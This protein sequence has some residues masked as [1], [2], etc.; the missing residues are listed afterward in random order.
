MNRA[1]TI[2]IA[3][4]AVAAGNLMAAVV[5]DFDKY[6]VILARKPFGEAPAA[7]VGPTPEQLKAMQK[8]QDSF[9]KYLQLIALTDDELGTRVGIYDKK[10]KSSFF[11]Y[12]GEKSEGGIKVLEA[13]FDKGQA[14]LQMGSETSVL[15]MDG[16]VEASEA[17][18]AAVAGSPK[19]RLIAPA[20]PNM[21]DQGSKP[22]KGR[23]LSYVERVRLRRERAKQLEQQ[24]IEE[25]AKRR[26]EQAGARELSPE[27]KQKLLREYNLE[28]IRAKGAKGQP[29]PMELTP[30][31][32]A[33]LVK[34]GVLPAMEE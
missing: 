19:K 18:P 7:P 29:L 15:F 8:P 11:L 22:D 20:I 34:E 26:L 30:E 12:V 27:E 23:T 14:E 32:D 3:L 10:S 9:A 24:R 16:R 33:Q 5:P 13:S 2:S 4:I 6:E 17:A 21:T 25:A 31:E 28:L 1:I